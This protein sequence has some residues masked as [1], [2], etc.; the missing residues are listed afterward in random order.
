MGAIIM[1]ASHPHGVFI[2][3]LLFEAKHILSNVWK[4]PYILLYSIFV[5]SLLTAVALTVVEM[6]CK[7][8]EDRL[9]HEAKW[10]ALE[11]ATWFSEHFAKT[12]IPLRSLQQAIM[13]SN[14][15]NDL[16]RQIGPYGEEGSAPPMYEPKSQGVKDYRNITGIC[17]DQV[18]QQHFHQIVSSIN[19]NFDLDGIIVNYL[20]APHGVFCLIDPLVNAADFSE[21]K[22]MNNKGTIG[23]D[24]IHSADSRWVSTLKRV[25]TDD[26]DNIDIYGPMTNFVEEGVEMF[27]AHLAVRMPSYNLTVDGRGTST[28]GFVMHFIN[29]SE[30]KAR[31][32]I[33][34][35][36][37]D[38]GMSFQLT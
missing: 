9:T 18:L 27:C 3:G 26:Q 29:W 2:N 15:F 38:K 36:F 37:L 14:Y 17:D 5:F 13:H 24:P 4:H 16:P 8:Q 21:G 19:K 25:Y 33:Y 30:V 28:W 34:Q 10:T 23:W 32:N 11:T 7:R 20:A 1:T 31:S 12:L 6:I 22:E 35:R